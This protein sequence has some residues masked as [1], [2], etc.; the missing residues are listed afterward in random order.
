MYATATIPTCVVGIGHALRNILSIRRVT[1]KPPNTLMLATRIPAT[2][3]HRDEGHIDGHLEQRADD[4]DPADGV[5]HRH[6]RCMQ[7]VVHVRDDVEP[8]DD[9]Q[10]EDGEVAEELRRRVCTQQAEKEAATTI[11]T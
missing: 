3:E 5:R 4:D 7:G 8:D 11:R 1:V 10:G 9:G 2:G 6:Q